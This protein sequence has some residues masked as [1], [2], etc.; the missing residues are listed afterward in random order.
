[1]IVKNRVNWLDDA[2]GLSVFGVLLAH[3]GVEHTVLYSFYTPFFLVLFFFISGMVFKSSSIR[4]DLLKV[5]KHLM[6]P[7][8]LLNLLILFLGGDNWSAVMTGN[9]SYVLTKLTNLLFG[10]LLWFIP[11]LIIVQVIS[12]FVLRLCKKYSAIKIPIIISFFFSV[13]IVRNESYYVLPWYADVALFSSSFFLLGNYIREKKNFNDWFAFHGVYSRIFAL[14]VLLVYIILAVVIQPK[15]NMEFHFAYNYYR[16]PVL[17]IFLALL[18]VFSVCVFFQT[19]HVGY[20]NFLGKNSLSFFAFNGK[21]FA[22]S[23]IL[24]SHIPVME[25]NFYVILFC[26]VESAILAVVAV[27]INRFVPFI[28]GKNAH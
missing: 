4:A 14:A 18:G 19:F 28:I 23:M 27:L 25:P 1:M 12:I 2:R 17:F 22:L 15:M 20:L 16:N 26:L 3:T 13:F 9:F 24:F 5:I 21:A 11:C 8:F 7:Y 6:I 10:K